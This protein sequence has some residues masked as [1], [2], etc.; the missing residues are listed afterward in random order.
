MDEL[1]DM[2]FNLKYQPFFQKNE[3]SIA[4][5][6]GVSALLKDIYICTRRGTGGYSAADFLVRGLTS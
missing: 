3:T 5:N 6:F 1:N 4:R 2:S